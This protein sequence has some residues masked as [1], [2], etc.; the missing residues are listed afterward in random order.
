MNESPTAVS[1]A[2]LLLVRNQW[3][4]CLLLSIAILVSIIQ[5]IIDLNATYMFI[6]LISRTLTSRH[7]SRFI[8]RK[9]CT[10]ACAKMPSFEETLIG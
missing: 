7:V 5:T 1:H 6:L 8:L 2:T 10:L 9:N 3:L 4:F